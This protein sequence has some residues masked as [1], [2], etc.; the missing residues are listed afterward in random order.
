MD[1]IDEGKTN[2]HVAVTSKHFSI[3]LGLN[4]GSSIC[5]TNDMSSAM[6]YYKRLPVLNA[7]CSP[8][9]FEP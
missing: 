5:I 3:L 7:R 9:C 8:L 2:R 6:E 1:V 4:L